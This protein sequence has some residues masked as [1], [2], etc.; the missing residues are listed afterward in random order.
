M[1]SVRYIFSICVVVLVTGFFSMTVASAKEAGNTSK[2]A[3]CP[4]VDY[5]S[6]TCLCVP[7]KKCDNCKCSNCTG[8]PKCQCMTAIRQAS[9]TITGSISI[10]KT[11]VK[12]K[13][14]KSYKDVVVYLEK[15]G[16]NNFPVSI[17][18]VRMDQKGLV[19]IPHVMSI[20]KGTNV[21]FLN[22][23]NDRHN[24]YFV[25]DKSGKTKDL[26]TWKP[27]ES[28]G[29]KFE[30]KH[31]DH[32]KIIKKTGKNGAPDTM[33]VLC[34]LH[35]EM[36]AYVVILDNPFFTMTSIDEKTQKAKY[37]IKNVPPGKYKLKI[38]HKKLKLKELE[39]EV[40]VEKGKKTKAD[41]EITKSKYAKKKG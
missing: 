20:Q 8:G 1:K 2:P 33:I 25:N 4:G 31:D 9:G 28:R 34:K 7:E 13:G 39:K 22:T 29:H 18:K 24:V 12:T 36:A 38:W 41:L 3:V 5:Q 6:D 19:F 15:V 21:E 26:G 30:K 10:Y 35:L 32:H 23:D 14:S 27:G 40:V 37:T 17:K 11:K 16:D